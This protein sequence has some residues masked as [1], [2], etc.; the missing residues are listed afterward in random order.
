MMINEVNFTKRIYEGHFLLPEGG[1][2]LGGMA[3]AP[4]FLMSGS[5]LGKKQ[6]TGID[7]SPI[8]EEALFS[9]T[10]LVVFCTRGVSPQSTFLMVQRDIYSACLDFGRLAQRT[11]SHKHLTTMTE[12]S[13]VNTFQ[14][15]QIQICDLQIKYEGMDMQVRQLCSY[16]PFVPLFPPCLSTSPSTQPQGS[17]GNIPWEMLPR[18]IL[19]TYGKFPIRKTYVHFPIKI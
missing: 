17:Q 18:K 7:S 4:Y 9:Q 13:W 5:C 19:G 1:K 10:H 16:L 12:R 11:T 8:S 6:S 15:P 14:T 3:Y 2:V